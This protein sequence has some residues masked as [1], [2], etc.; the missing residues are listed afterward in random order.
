MRVILWSTVRNKRACLEAT[1]SGISG[2][3]NACGIVLNRS[4]KGGL[5]FNWMRWVLYASIIEATT[6]QRAQVPTVWCWWWERVGRHR[7]YVAHPDTIDCLEGKC[8]MQC[9]VIVN[10]GVIACASTNVF[11]ASVYWS[12]SSIKR[13]LH[14]RILATNR[15]ADFSFPVAWK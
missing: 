10:G 14:N 15:Q 5:T 13:C 3:I 7:T 12:T 1:R 11:T 4:K 2:S 6:R 9:R 8:N